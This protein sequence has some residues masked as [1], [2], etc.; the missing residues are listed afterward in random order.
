ML[1]EIHLKTDALKME[2][3]SCRPVTAA[4]AATAAMVVTVATSVA[5]SLAETVAMTS[6]KQ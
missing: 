4:M 6:T 5:A 2:C 3:L 1:L